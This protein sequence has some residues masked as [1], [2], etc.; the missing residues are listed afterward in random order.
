MTVTSDP[1]N[2]MWAGGLTAL[3][4]AHA[5]WAYRKHRKTA[6]AM[7]A[8]AEAMKSG[9]A[10]TVLVAYG[11]QTGLAAE[12]AEKT[13]KAL[14]DASVSARVISLAELDID[15]LKEARRILFIVSTTGEGDAPD[16]ATGFL[17]RCMTQ[18][19]D[20]GQLSY[21]VLALG[22]SSYEHYCAFGRQLDHWLEASKAH[23]IF[24][25]IEVDNGRIEDIHHWQHHL[26]ALTGSTTDHDWSP[27]AYDGWVLS[28]RR[29]MNS[30]SPGGEV[31]HLRFTP[32]GHDTVWQAGDIAEIVIPAQGEAPRLLREYSIASLPT[33]GGIEFCVRLATLPDGGFGAGSGWLIR[34]LK[35]GAEVEMRVRRN[36]AFR[37]VTP[38]VPVI[39]IGN[40][41]GIA[42]LRAHLK[43][44]TG[45]APTW[46]LYGERS[47][48]H[49]ALY[50]EEL[51][52]MLAD[53]RLTRLDR[54]WSRDGGEKRYVQHLINENAADIARSIEEDATVF[55]CGSL[56]GM[57]QGVH[58]ALEAALGK[59]KLDA[60]IDSQRYRR[61][62]Y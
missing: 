11:S 59:D 20:L 40:G 42:G 56:D 31:W 38:Q 35:L 49:D 13:A 53:G 15:T 51:Q 54:A 32:K 37:P 36:P 9:A 16:N 33:D 6:A 39:L 12:L 25:R 45:Q 44:R 50:D 1:A 47:Q 10:R 18:P 17:R 22:D 23:H 28:E 58:A 3:W 55:V 19:M 7:K 60:L 43:T 41:T 24:E 29:L 46:L 4:L 5:G 48:A 61:D 34:S 27:P 62:V 8:R 26:S 2:W 14:E 57:S 30:G 52:A 21:A